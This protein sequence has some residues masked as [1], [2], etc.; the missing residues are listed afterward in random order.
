MSGKSIKEHFFILWQRGDGIPDEIFEGIREAQVR[1]LTNT[2]ATT[3][4]LRIVSQRSESPTRARARVECRLQNGESLQ[5][6]L[7]FVQE[8]GDWKPVYRIEP[9]PSGGVTAYFFH[10]PTP[11]LGPVGN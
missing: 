8:D 2:V 5:R 4:A 1:N 7:E 3:A 10:V 11:E 6:E 9:T